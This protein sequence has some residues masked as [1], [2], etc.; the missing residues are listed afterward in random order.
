MD[1]QVV[2]IDGCQGREMDFVIFSCVV[3]DMTRQNFLQEHNRI[4]V[5]LSRA[6]HGLIL[7]GNV[8]GLKCDP[9]WRSLIEI[10]SSCDSIVQGKEG[11]IAKIETERAKEDEI[12]MADDDFM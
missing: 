4:N 8:E 2:T 11:A 10:F 12:Q 3:Q 9:Q 1:N 6:K 5:A 7:V